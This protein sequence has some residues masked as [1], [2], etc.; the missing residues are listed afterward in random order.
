M[1][2]TSR[3]DG[4]TGNKFTLPLKETNDGRNI[5]NNGLH[6]A[7]HQEKGAWPLWDGKQIRWAL[8]APAYC[9]SLSRLHHRQRKLE[10]KE[11][12]SGKPRTRYWRG[13][14]LHRQRIW[15]GQM[16]EYSA[17]YVSTKAREGSTHRIRDKN[18]WYL[19]LTKMKRLQDSHSRVLPRQWR[20]TVLFR[21]STFLV[22]PNKL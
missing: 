5:G 2:F 6:D 3:K 21:L 13:K 17:E 7:G 9:L 4:A 15:R 22:S 19:H 12:S 18:A 14:K 1:P 10:E 20:I 16:I 11:L 8:I